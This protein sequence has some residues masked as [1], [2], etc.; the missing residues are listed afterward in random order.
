MLLQIYTCTNCQTLAIYKLLQRV[1]LLLKI[2]ELLQICELA[3]HKKCLLSV[4]F[5]ST[6]NITLANLPFFNM[7]YIKLSLFVHSQTMF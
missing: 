7:F 2:Y 3:G 1:L 4:H 6:V 5:K